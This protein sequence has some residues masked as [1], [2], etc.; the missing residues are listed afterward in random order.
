MIAKQ[1]IIERFLRYVTVDTESDPNS[2]TTPSSKNQWDLANA[3]AQELKDIG[4]SDISIDK[5][6]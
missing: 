2:Q 1:H 4:M 3:L 6:A 5:H